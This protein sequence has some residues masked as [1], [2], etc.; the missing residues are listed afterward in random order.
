M[1][2]RFALV[3]F[4]RALYLIVHRLAGKG[5]FSIDPS[6]EIIYYRMLG[7]HI[8]KNVFIDPLARLGEFD[9]LHLQDDCRIDNSQVRGFC[10]ERNGFFR[11]DYVNI[12]RKV[13]INTYTVVCPGAVIPDGSVYGPHASS[14]DDPSPASYA[15]Y[16][17]TLVPLPHWLLMMFVAW[18]LISVVW[19]ISR[20]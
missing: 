10:V 5:I 20:S 11:L 18:P 1:S 12:G 16:N 7:A 17:R 14:N 13:A 2:L 15:A 6:L 4:L 8:G 3:F 9:L 19:I